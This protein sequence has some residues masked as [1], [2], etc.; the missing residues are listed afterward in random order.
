MLEINF[1]QLGPGNPLPPEWKL[2][3]ISDPML[4]RFLP[5]SL[6]LFV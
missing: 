4:H 3:S 5:I 1:Q 2:L 6:R